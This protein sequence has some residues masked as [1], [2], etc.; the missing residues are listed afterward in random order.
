MAAGGGRWGGVHLG[1]RAGPVWC[2]LAFAGAFCGGAGGGGLGGCRLSGG[3]VW[4][5]LRGACWLVGRGAGRGCGFPSLRGS[6]LSLLSWP[7]FSFSGS[8]RVSLS[9]GAS[10]SG[11]FA[12]CLS[13]ALLWRRPFLSC[14]SS[15]GPGAR[16]FWWARSGPLWAGSRVFSALGSPVR[17]RAGGGARSGLCLG[18]LPPAA[19]ACRPRGGACGGRRLGPRLLGAPR[20]AVLR[21]LGR[22]WVPP[23]VRSSRRPAGRVGG[24]PPGSARSRGRAVRRAGGAARP[25]GAGG[26]GGGWGGGGGAG[27]LGRGGRGGGGGGGGGVLRFVCRGGSGGGSGRVP[28]AFND[29]RARGAEYFTGQRRDQR[30]K[31]ATSSK[32]RDLQAK[33]TSRSSHAKTKLTQNQAQAQQKIDRKKTQA[34]TSFTK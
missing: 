27:W 34:K 29:R 24:A 8:A 4:W 21:S 3:A 11:G 15:G 19:R 28:C 10:F 7:L 26:G 20:P 33:K 32:K 23:S 16:G 31:A 14:P 22:A 2:G 1:V 25:P 17:A 30:S 12:V 13:G 9:L 18:G 5:F 6:G